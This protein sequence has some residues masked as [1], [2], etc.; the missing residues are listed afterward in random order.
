MGV[1]CGIQL[2]KVHMIT[3][4]SSPCLFWLLLGLILPVALGEPIYRDGE[5]RPLAAVS[6]LTSR[7]AT[8]TQHLQ[9]LQEP[10][11]PLPTP[12]DLETIKKVAQILVM[13]GEQVIPAVIGEKPPSN[14]SEI[15]E[16]PVNENS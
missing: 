13:L 8:H 7:L 5:Y 3:M 12:P 2:M 11:L 9:P 4:C 16:D 14:N 10:R 6:E 15:T 1:E